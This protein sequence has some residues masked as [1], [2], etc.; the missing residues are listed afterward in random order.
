MP[1]PELQTISKY[2]STLLPLTPQFLKEHLSSNQLWTQS[3]E[4]QTY[5]LRPFPDLPAPRSD[6]KVLQSYSVSHRG[7][8]QSPNNPLQVESSLN[9]FRVTF[10][11]AFITAVWVEFAFFYAYNASV[12]PPVS[13]KLCLSNPAHTILAVNVLSH[14]TIFLLSIL[15]SDVFEGIRWVLACGGGISMPTFLSLSRAT[16]PIRVLYLFF[17][18]AK[19][20][21]SFFQRP[22]SLGLQAVC[23]EG[24]I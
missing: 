18:R 16:S 17:H 24:A 19:S 6:L 5:P 9:Q 3:K 15:S 13:R 14:V 2:G 22:S 1:A 21:L 7:S 12:D 10:L 8:R 23:L 11:I 20:N 4:A